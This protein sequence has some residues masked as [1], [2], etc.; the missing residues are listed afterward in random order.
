M[1][2]VRASVAVL[3]LSL[4]GVLVTSSPEPIDATS[5]PEQAESYT[6]PMHPEVVEP[7]PGRCPKCKM[8]LVP[9]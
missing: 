2:L 6:C 4:T 1:M 8:K 9:K 3:A 7:K 5:A